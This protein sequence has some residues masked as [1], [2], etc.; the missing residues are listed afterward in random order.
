MTH[1][2]LL[3]SSLLSPSHPLSPSP[4]PTFCPAVPSHPP[5]GSLLL[6]VR[7]L[8]IIG[9]SLAHSCTHPFFP[10]SL[11][12]THL[13]TLR[14]PPRPAPPR[15]APPHPTPPGPAPAPTP[16]YS[17]ECLFLST[18]PSPSR[19]APSP[20]LRPPTPPCSTYPSPAPPPPPPP[21][22]PGFLSTPS[23]PPLPSLPSPSSPPPQNRVSSA[24]PSA[25]SP[26]TAPLGSR[27]RAFPF[28]S[29]C[30]YKTVCVCERSMRARQQ[31]CGAHQ[32]AGMC[33]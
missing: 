8:R 32:Y 9:L 20:P 30:R 13:L 17:S 23:A 14:K 31:G 6:P 2:P 15:P 21:S 29:S 16:P 28:S 3:P 4:P 10:H 18:A 12:K 33:Q 5:S 27:R 22:E 7:T 11:C 1:I 19:P 26:S 25:P 24:P